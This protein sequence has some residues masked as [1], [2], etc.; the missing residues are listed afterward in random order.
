MASDPNPAAHAHES[1][2]IMT[3]PLIILAVLSIFSGWTFSYII[4][5]PFGTPTLE[6]MLE[7]GEPYRAWSIESRHHN[8]ALASA[9]S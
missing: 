5:L 9:R 1:E 4:P 8:Y 2:P 3:W 7:Y 6:H